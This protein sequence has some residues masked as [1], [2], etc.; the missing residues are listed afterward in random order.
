MS[1]ISAALRTLSPQ[2]IL[3]DELGGLDEVTALEQGLFLRDA[4]PDT[5]AVCCENL[6]KSCFHAPF[7]MAHAFNV[8]SLCRRHNADAVIFCQDIAFF[9][10]HNFSP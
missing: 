8:K 3:L 9:I 2:V 1:A 10:C 6:R 4:F 5:F 7:G